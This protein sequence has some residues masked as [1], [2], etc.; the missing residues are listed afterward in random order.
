VAR[1]YH[2]EVSYAM[3]NLVTIIEPLLILILGTAVG[4][5]I[6]AIIMPMYNLTSAI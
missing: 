4:V 5:L 2:K 6:V 1:F 3:D